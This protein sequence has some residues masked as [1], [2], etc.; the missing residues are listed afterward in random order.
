GGMVREQDYVS[1]GYAV[2][3]NS[4]VGCMA[5][6]GLNGLYLPGLRTVGQAGRAWYVGYSGYTVFNAILAPNGP[7]CNGT[8]WADGPSI[9]PPT[10]YHPGGVQ[11][12]LCDGSVRFINETIDT[13]NLALPNVVEGASP[14]GVW[15]AL[16]SMYGSE[17]FT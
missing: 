7:S 11:A 8:P 6:R 5:T 12:T 3:V 17:V 1:P 2:N 4:P 13:G 15:G 16:G 9:E 10:S 14:Y